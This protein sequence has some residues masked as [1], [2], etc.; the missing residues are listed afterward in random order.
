MLE[1]PKNEIFPDIHGFY[2][3]ESDIITITI[4]LE[5]KKKNNIVR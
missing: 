1:V 4:Q 3:M 5:K 2:D